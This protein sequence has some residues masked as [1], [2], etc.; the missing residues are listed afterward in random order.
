M[1]ETLLILA[2]ALG[3][4]LLSTRLMKLI[5]FPNVTGYLIVGLLI[6]PYCLDVINSGSIHTLEII[7]AVALGFI[8][9]SIGSSFKLKHLKKI[10]K[11][12]VVITL[13]QAF[14]TLI[15][16]DIIFLI[17]GLDAPMAIMFGAIAT[18]TAPAATLMVVRQYKAKGPVTNTLLPVVAFDD[19]IGLMA[20][21]VSL[22]IA[23]VL[24]VGTGITFQSTVFEPLLEIALSLI[25]GG[26]IGLCLA[27][28]SRFFKSRANRITLIIT[29]IFLGLLI[30][31]SLK[32]SDLLV[33]MMI[34]A[35][36]TNLF[37]EASRPLDV[38]DRWTYPCYMLFFVISGAE[39]DIAALPT[40]GIIG[41]VYIIA[42]AIGKY[43]GARFGAGIVKA[44][45][46]VTKY[47]GYTLLPQAGVAIG[48]AQKVV[49]A[50][51]EYGRA[52]STVILCATLIY[53]LVGPVLT[54]Y[55][56]TKAGEIKK[57]SQN[58]KKSEGA[59]A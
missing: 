47:L 40:V 45:K 19:A 31:M 42:R 43:F 12:V 55:A 28:S 16:L 2:C 15:L 1:F 53:E 14:F 10:G 9:F 46:N 36:Y 49:S 57:E 25:V 38:F 30:S 37:K 44:D 33:C 17:W 58:P 52:I 18:A 27:L 22:A 5:H 50:L 7:T 6:G 26:V 21:S 54:K 8:A 24:A 29:A 34:G 3:C 32:L 35:M 51:P 48:M 11:N 4:G 20:F 39:L 23:E 59:S 13:C 56:L 41:I